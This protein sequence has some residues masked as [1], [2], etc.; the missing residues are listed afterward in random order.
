MRTN[1]DRALNGRDMAESALGPE[2]GMALEDY[3]SGLTDALANLMHFA[4]RY[5]IDFDVHLN[6]ARRHHD[7]EK[8]TPWDEIPT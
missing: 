4:R 3:E 7:A 1:L 8:S 2:S 5:S 6:I